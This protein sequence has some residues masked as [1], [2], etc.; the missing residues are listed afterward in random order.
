MCLILQTIAKDLSV[1]S[2]STVASKSA[3]NTS[4]QILKPHHRQLNW[5]TLEVLMCFK[6]W[7]WSIKKTGNLNYIVAQEYAIVLNEMDYVMK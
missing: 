1:I 5:T 2:I 6:S 7:L 3:F 4:G